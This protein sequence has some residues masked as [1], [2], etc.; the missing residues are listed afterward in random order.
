MFVVNYKAQFG[1]L[2]KYVFEEITIVVTKQ[3]RLEEKVN[4][5]IRERE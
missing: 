1:K 3:R 2:S 4:L 5:R